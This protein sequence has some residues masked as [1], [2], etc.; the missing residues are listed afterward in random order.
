M[1]RRDFLLKSSLITAGIGVGLMGC[2]NTTVA[3]VPVPE[4]ERIRVGIIGMGNRGTTIIKVLNQLPAIKI[5]ACC[6]ILDF[7]LEEGLKNIND[8]A[9]GYSDYR[10]LLENKDLEAV[11]ISA[12][13]HEHYRMVMDALDADIHIMCEK[14]LAH[15]IEQSRDIKLKADE[16]SKLFQ[17]S[18]QYQLNPT[19]NAIKDII[20]QGYL[21]K[22]TRIDASW[23]RN[24]N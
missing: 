18:Y 13:L 14:A 19:V 10:K 5:I 4:G 16:S 22:I 11:I 17:V 20:Q 15:N 2:R 7:R 6:D 3:P 8:K 12:P 9:I 24:S 1:E 23:H 21:G